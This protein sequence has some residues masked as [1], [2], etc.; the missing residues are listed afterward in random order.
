MLFCVCCLVCSL[1]HSFF[2]V[3]S[4]L[5]DHSG[6]KTA[7]V[8]VFVSGALNIQRAQTVEMGDG[9]IID[10]MIPPSESVEPPLGTRDQ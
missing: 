7:F 10:D 8:F 4:D 3:G 5:V 2:Y 6:N 1:P 9:S